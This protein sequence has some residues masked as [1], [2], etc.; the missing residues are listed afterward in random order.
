MSDISNYNS[1][2]TNRGNTFFDSNNLVAKFAFL[3]VVIFG[4]IILLKFGISIIAYFM[5]PRQSPHLID[6]MVDAKN[7]LVFSQDA[8][9]NNNSVTIYRSVN[10][11][12]GLEFTWS[13]WVYINTLQYLQGQYKSIFYKVNS[14][15]ATDGN[16]LNFPN[17]APGLYI[18][19]DK[20]DLIVIMNTFDVINEEIRI[21]NIPLNKWMNVI[22]R[23]QNK[24]LDVYV[25]GTIARS[26]ELTSVPKQNYGDVYVGM[27][28]GFD[29]Y[30]S[31]LWY[32]NYSLGAAAIQNIAQMGPNTKMLGNNG[33]NMKNANYLSLRWYFSGANNGFNP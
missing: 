28:G 9:G 30:I 6:G 29:G 32:Y 15:L 27:N 11:R 25:N 24:T 5:S 20:N 12:D 22:I 1:F 18:D 26:L 14:N 10:K 16:G 8:S 3:L 21:P 7:S 13:V 23:C 31:N 17:N 19:P 4:F 33:M 2:S